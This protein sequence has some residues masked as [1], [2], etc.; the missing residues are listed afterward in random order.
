MFALSSQEKIAFQGPD[1]IKWTYMVM[2]FGPT[3]GQAAFINF[4]YD[5]DSQWKALATSSRVT[6]NEET[7]TRIIVDDILSHG[8]DL[9]TSLKYMKCQL[10]VCLA[11]HRL[12]SLR[13]SHLFF[14]RFEFVGNDV[15]ADGNHPAQSKHQLLST[16]PKP[17]LVKYIAKFIGFVQFYS[18]YINH[19][20][21][22]ATPLHELT[23]NNEYTDPVAPIWFNAVQHAL[24]NLK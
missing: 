5:G 20:E 19:F 8:K 13:K 23:I 11:Y 16:W 12:L 9:D 6:I 18:K 17:K 4:I 2:P 22:K 14:L 15:C 10:C 24:N 7:N 1:A 3:N 21:V